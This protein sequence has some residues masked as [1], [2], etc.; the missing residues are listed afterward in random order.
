[1][2]YVL[3]VQDCEEI[4]NFAVRLLQRRGYNAYAVAN[5]AEALDVLHDSQ[6]LPCLILLDV[7]TPVMDGVAFRRQQKMDPRIA[8]IP[9]IVFSSYSNALRYGAQQLFDGHVCLPFEPTELIQAVA[10]YYPPSYS[11]VQK[12]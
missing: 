4:A 7:C 6:H 5:S 2:T 1:M 11:D 12:D 3:I 10:R 9:V 8:D